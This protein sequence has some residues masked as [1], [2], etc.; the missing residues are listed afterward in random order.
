MRILLRE[1]PPVSFFRMTHGSETVAI[2]DGSTLLEL[3][4]T[5]KLE[6]EED[7]TLCAVPAIEPDVL[8]LRFSV[9][10]VAAKDPKKTA[11]IDLAADTIARAGK[12]GRESYRAQDKAWY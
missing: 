4:T 1:E 3:P 9:V 2:G 11:D 12:E 8:T 10:K 7:G 5:F 6:S